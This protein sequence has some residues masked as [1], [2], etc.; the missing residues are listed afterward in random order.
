[1]IPRLRIG[2]VVVAGVVVGLAVA[3]RL[4]AVMVGEPAS[5][6]SVLLTIGTAA[7]V[8]GRRP[9]PVLAAVAAATF[10]TIGAVTGEPVLDGFW[11]GATMAALAWTLAARGTGRCWLAPSCWRRLTC[12]VAG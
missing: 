11:I 12:S 3:E 1:M 7:A 8:L 2:D 5:W 4:D 10:M 9:V 6:L